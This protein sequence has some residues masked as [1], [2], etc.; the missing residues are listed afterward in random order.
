M[1]AGVSKGL[2]KSDMARASYGE[3]LGALGVALSDRVVLPPPIP[4]TYVIRNWQIGAAAAKFDAIAVELT[5]DMPSKL[6]DRASASGKGSATGTNNGDVIDIDAGSAVVLMTSSAVGGMVSKNGI[7]YIRVAASPQG[8]PLTHSVPR[9]NTKRN[10][11]LLANRLGIAAVYAGDP[12]IL[13]F[14]NTTSFFKVPPLSPGLTG[15]L[16]EGGVPTLAAMV[17]SL[18]KSSGKLSSYHVLVAVESFVAYT[19]TVYGPAD[20]LARELPSLL[21]RIKGWLGSEATTMSL[22]EEAWDA[23]AEKFLQTSQELL[24]EAVLSGYTHMELHTTLLHSVVIPSFTAAMEQEM[25]IS[26]MMQRTSGGAGGPSG[27]PNAHTPQPRTAKNPYKRSVPSTPAAENVLP[28]SD[29]AVAASG[30][31]S[32]CGVPQ[33]APTTDGGG[34]KRR[35]AALATECGGVRPNGRGVCYF[36]G[37][38]GLTC[39]KGDTCQFVHNNVEAQP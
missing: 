35:R 26:T 39:H 9:Q 19:Q 4:D 28:T 7:C 29:G 21:K 33:L 17:T 10:V 5:K 36:Y 23:A 16:E 13:A 38:P 27:V 3:A 15:V 1:N 24:A 18:H 37:K 2:F 25:L 6:M 30:A 34:G 31:R 32:D 20:K 22:V 11:N 8:I 14:V 12:G